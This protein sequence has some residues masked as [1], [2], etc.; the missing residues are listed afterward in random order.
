M[1]GRVPARLTASEGRKFGLG[2]GSAFLLIAAVLWWRDH[3][4][5][6]QVIGGLGGI[7]ILGGLFV[8]SQLGPVYRAWMAL[9]VL[10]SKVTTP[11]FMA[12]LY[13]VVLTPA[14]I[15]R[16]NLGANPMRHE[17]AEGGFWKTREAGSRRGSLERQF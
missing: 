15:V 9:A 8:P 4:V 13:F 3:R 10:I 12:I 17:E 14:G 2:V 7:L 1:A 16:R 11:I 5:A 6:M